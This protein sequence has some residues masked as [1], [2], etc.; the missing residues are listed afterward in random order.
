M[1]EGARRLGAYRVVSKPFDM[2][3]VE[4]L[5]REAYEALPRG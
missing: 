2:H 4:T 5:T 1:A 3:A